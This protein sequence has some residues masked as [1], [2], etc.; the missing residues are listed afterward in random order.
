[1][2]DKVMK[3]TKIKFIIPSWHYYSDPMKHQP[4]WELYYASYV[5]NAGFD[6][7]IFDMRKF[8]NL[9]DL[10]Y[11]LINMTEQEYIEIQKNILNFN[12]S[13][14]S[15]CYKPAYFS[16]NIYENLLKIV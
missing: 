2:V 10:H 3:N 1:M 15:L 13:K 12:N 9:S 11:Y 4:Y 14:K 8:N 16:S 5:K 7:S 6:V